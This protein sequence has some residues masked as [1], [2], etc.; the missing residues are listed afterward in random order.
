MRRTQ[1]PIRL[2][3]LALASSLALAVSDGATDT[4]RQAVEATLASAAACKGLGDYYWE[5]GNAGG[6]L[7]SGQSGRMISAQRPIRV[8][9]ASKWLFG[10]YVAEKT[11]GQL[12]AAQ[13]DALEMKSGYDGLNPFGCAGASTIDACLDRGGNGRR[14][15]AHVGKFS[16]NGGHDQQLAHDLGLGGM[17][18]V[19]LSRDLQET[20]GLDVDYVAPQPAG[21]MRT[22]PAVYGAFLR[23]ILNGQLQMAKLLGSH[24]VCTLPSQCADAAESPSPYAWHYSINHW[25][26]DAP[27]EDGAFSSPGMFGFYPWITADRSS[28]GVLARVSLE[29]G[30]YLR[31]ARCGIAMRHA[32][33][34]GR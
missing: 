34:A 10:A 3:L 11:Q 31:S 8:A 22:T 26:E 21:G 19:A 16:Y 7:A 4:R 27:G 30:A 20:L 29:P 13:L 32:W 15:E 18:T 33:A 2:C 14:N 6:V 5:I 25:I 24:A 12:T 1:S 23:K 28:Y 9:S 17:D